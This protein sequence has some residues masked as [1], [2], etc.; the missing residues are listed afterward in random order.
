MRILRWPIPVILTNIL[1]PADTFVVSRFQNL[2]LESAET[3]TVNVDE[4]CS[5]SKPII[6]QFLLGNVFH[7][8]RIETDLRSYGSFEMLTGKSLESEY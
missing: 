5:F 4:R 3:E 1:C 7:P 2:A 8:S 6:G